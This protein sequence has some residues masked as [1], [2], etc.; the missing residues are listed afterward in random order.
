MPEICTILIFFKGLCSTFGD[1]SYTVG[2]QHLCNSL[3]AT[4]QQMTTYREFRW[5]SKAQL[6]V[7]DKS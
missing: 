4:V 1:R 5:H 3:Q 2:E 7:A 6:F